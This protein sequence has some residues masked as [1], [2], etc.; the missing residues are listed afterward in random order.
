MKVKLSLQWLVFSRCILIL[1]YWH[2]CLDFQVEAGTGYREKGWSWGISDKRC[3]YLFIKALF[4]KVLQLILSL[5]YHATVLLKSN[6]RSSV[7]LYEMAQVRKRTQ[8]DMLLSCCVF[9]NN[10]VLKFL[11]LSVLVAC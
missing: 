3:D 5:I 8:T 1:M 4:H 11:L 6:S 9:Q 7:T 2:I 10:F